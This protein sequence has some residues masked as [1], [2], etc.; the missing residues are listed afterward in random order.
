[1]VLQSVLSALCSSISGA[2]G[3]L[4]LDAAGEV[5]VESEH[6]DERLRL[7]GAYHGIA[8]AAARKAAERYSVGSIEYF[9]SR[10]T[11]GTVVSRPLK[12][13][14]YFVLSLG[15]DSPVAVAV[16]RSEIAQQRLN[17]EI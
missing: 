17:D 7:I 4:L 16:H 12:D 9:V 8:L 15:P 5:V 6:S 13:N 14:Y 3:A 2:Q 11:W 10:H 1:M